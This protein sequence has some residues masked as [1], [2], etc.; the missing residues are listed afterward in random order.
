M[1][2]ILWRHAEAEEGDSDD[3]RKLTAKGRKQAAWISEWLLHRLPSKITV[4]AAPARPARETAETLCARIRISD[5]LAP[6]ASVGAI[7]EEAGWPSHNGSVV[8]LVGHQP[9]LGRVAARLISGADSNWTV[10]KGGL[11]W[12]TNRVRNDEAQVVVRA[13]IAPDL[14]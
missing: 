7:L 11:W 12:L 8:V 9:D 14:V 2:L 5:C 10:K 6:G 13:V 3:V 4:V 1:D